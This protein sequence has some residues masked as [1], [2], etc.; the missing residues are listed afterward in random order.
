MQP[1]PP[2]LFALSL[3][4]SGLSISTCTA[5]AIAGVMGMQTCHGNPLSKCCIQCATSRH[6]EASETGRTVSAEAESLPPCLS[7]AIRTCPAWMAELR[8]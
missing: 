4:F 5:A 3:S 2:L 1:P 6:A 7:W 8:A